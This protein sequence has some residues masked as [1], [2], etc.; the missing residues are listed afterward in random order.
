MQHLKKFTILTVIIFISISLYS[1]QQE[2]FQAITAVVVNPEEWLSLS[3]A[4]SVNNI[5]KIIKQIY[6][7]KFNT[8]IFVVN[9]NGYAVYKSSYLAF[10]NIDGKPPVYF[11]YI[12]YIINETKKYNLKFFVLI[13]TLKNIKNIKTSWLCRTENNTIYEPYFLSCGNPEVQKFVRDF[14]KEF[15][16]SYNVDGIILT[17]LKYPDEHTSYDYVSTYRFYTRGNPKLLE[18]EDFQRQQ[19][20]KLLCDIYTDIKLVSSTTLV[21]VVV[22]S[23]Y[24]TPAT[25]TG[26]YYKNFQDTKLWV[27]KNYCDFLTIE[28]SSITDINKVQELQKMLP[29]KKLFLF[30]TTKDDNLVK[31]ITQLVTML[32]GVA[33]KAIPKE[34]IF[35][36]SAVFPEIEPIPAIIC[37]T[38][39]D[40]NLSA[41]VDAWVTLCSSTTEVDFTLSSVDGRF[42]FII[43]SS[44][45][46]YYNITIEYPWCQKVILS[47]VTIQPNTVVVVEP[48][49]IPYSAE[50]KDKLFFYIY[51][52]KDLSSIDKNVIHI[53]GRTFPTNKIEF[54]FDNV[55][56]TVKVYPTGM[57]A[58]DNINLKP[59][60]NILTFTI[61]DKKTMKIT[62]QFI[63][64]TYSTAAISP[65]IITEEKLPKLI[66]PEQDMLLFSN[67]VLEIK[68]QYEPSKKVFV[69]CF[70]NNEK[71]LLDEI[72]CGVYYKR[73]LIPPNFLSQKTVLKLYTTQ[74]IKKSFFRKEEI[75]VPIELDKEISIEVWNSAYPLIAETIS[76]K[77]PITYGLHYVRLGGPYITELP[78]GIKLQ[79]IGKQQNYYKVKLS[80]SLSGWVE[81]KNVV[82]HKNL[83]EPPHNY[84]TYCSISAEKNKDKI[85][86]P[87]K[88][89]VAFSVTPATEDNKNY[90][91][92]DFFNTHFATT[93]L[94][95]KSAA[96]ILDNFKITQ[97][98]DDWLRIYIPVKTKQLWGYNVETTTGGV[99]IYVKYP[100]KI[101]KENPL[102]GITIAL[103]AGHGGETNTGA[104][105]LSG[106]KEKNINY[107]AVILLKSILE[108]NGAKVVLVRQ[109]DTNPNFDQRIKTAVDSNADIFV[110]IHS[111][112]GS[113]DKGFLRVSGTSV[114]YKYD[115]SKLFAECVYNEILKLWKDDFGLVGNFNYTPLRQTYFPAIL[116]EQ[117]FLT[118]PYD[119]ARMLDKKFLYQQAEAITLGIK[120]FLSKVVE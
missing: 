34:D 78:K 67:D 45:T 70:D 71:I 61:S 5:N 117:G 50:E 84:F 49:K 102:K 108:K 76:D 110:S 17:N 21:S 80:A 60:D 31:K 47:S 100:P 10:Y 27:E 89:P 52:P 119:E 82:L 35:T 116:I 97:V 75:F 91:V 56:T 79:V 43:N 90:I 93:W 98:E 105:G 53:L 107:H 38:I 14:I 109:G 42:S 9:K 114:Y 18:Y 87:W 69:S 59:A 19:L 118:H 16:F 72:S 36:I 1:A 13:D 2:S 120:K 54:Y 20:N 22:P 55:S 92:I 65:T 63:K 48:I 8:V 112:A 29:N 64:V 37:G 40:D 39:V 23:E 57:F 83:Y 44:Q 32:K 4:T 74:V 26:S 33:Y 99:T 3:T 41:L 11:D 106:A 62:Q 95:Y 96:K 86:I 81:E 88:I 12:S 73:H 24:K 58:I 6:D 115:N 77:T 25:L 111:N 15:V 113:T 85:W 7:K 51:Q 28:I 66:L 46:Y 101:N 103:E 30:V 104:I 94:T 68:L